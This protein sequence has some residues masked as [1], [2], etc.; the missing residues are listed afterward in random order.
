MADDNNSRYQPGEHQHRDAGHKNAVNDPLA[1]LARL[2]GQSDPFGETAQARHRTGP[3]HQVSPALADRIHHEQPP[4]PAHDDFRFHAPELNRD[5][6]LRD[7][8]GSNGPSAVHFDERAFFRRLHESH[9]ETPPAFDIA[10]VD[11][12]PIEPPAAES[13]F[14]AKPFVPGV[15]QQPGSREFRNSAEHDS[16]AYGAPAYN[17]DYG[18]DAMPVPREQETYEEPPPRRRRGLR[19]VA[20]VM[21]LAVVGIAGAVGY[22]VLWNGPA[23]SGPPPVI[24]AS[25]EPAKV[26]P[27]PTQA[28]P[29][30]PGRIGFDRFAD[31]GKDEQVIRREETPVDLREVTRNPAPRSAAPSASAPS[32]NPAWPGAPPVPP[33]AAANSTGTVNPPSVIGEPRRVRTVPIRP[34]QS[35]IAANTPAAVADVTAPRQIFP[36]APAAAA[37][38]SRAANAAQES[39]APETSQ[40]TVPPR[41]APAAR[42]P[43]PQAAAGKTPLSLAPEANANAARPPVAV[44]NAGSR[45]TGMSPPAVAPSRQA[46][47]TPNP[48]TNSARGGRFY[49]QVTSQRS[50]TDAEAAFRS[51]QSKFSSVLASQ[52]HI[53][54]RADLG[55]KG[56]Y[57]RALVGPFNSRDGAVQLC[58]SLKSAGGDCLVQTN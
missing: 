43:A 51:V 22:R 56:I 19:T 1:E 49:V 30:S 39:P 38:P 40:R 21:A 26:T 45:D 5:E 7:E 58:T 9:S 2:I 37:A 32:S 12:G 44:R 27:P 3:A 10:A 46:S 11:A 29:S 20:A 16:Y 18:H 42:T 34:E 14:G 50:Q 53:I 6:S 47:V 23:A 55:N 13:E 48:A 28:E 8:R 35:D 57:F 17:G 41:S 31:R 54:Q 33:P 15:G 4:A 36:P 52:P 24:R 25:T